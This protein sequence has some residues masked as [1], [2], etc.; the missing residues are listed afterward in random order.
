MADEVPWAEFDITFP[1]QQDVQVQVR[2]SLEAAG[3]LPYIWFNYI[4]STGAGW[5]DTIGSAELT[6]RFPYPVSELNYIPS[7]PANDFPATTQGGQVDGNDIT[8]TWTDFEPDEMD[9][10]QITLVTPPVWFDIL[11]E[12][13]QVQQ[14]PSDGEAWGRLGKQYKQILMSPHG[15]RG[16]R[17]YT[18]KGDPGAQEIYR[19]SVEAYEKSLDLLPDDALWHAG[20]ADL[21]GWYGY[22]AGWEGYDTLPQK[23]E[24]LEEIKLA[25]E[26]AP[27]NEQV[28]QIAD[29]LSFYMDEG[30]VW[31][32]SEYDFP[33]LTATPKPTVT[34]IIPVEPNP[35]MEL[36]ITETPVQAVS[37]V[38]PTA[39]DQ[40]AKPAETTEPEKPK[41]TLPFCG[42]ALLLPA[43]L[44]LV[45]LRKP[46]K[47]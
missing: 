3:E 44:L 5:K 21:L 31:N 36:V 40:A 8:W 9:N 43:G 35:T 6:V 20:Y 7:N 39:T 25:L 19:L 23:L 10:F 15:G 33:W 11:H 37:P 32:G 30:M 46:G 1:P 38:S 41:R 42:S 45:A 12:Q 27:G 13:E 29:V 34:E 2:Y 18:L 47:S 26:L 28:K 24:A 17:D 16:F 22:Y 14:N 4:F